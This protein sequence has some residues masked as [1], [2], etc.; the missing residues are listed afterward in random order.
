[1]SPSPARGKI[2]AKGGDLMD[3]KL[4]NEAK[5]MLCVLYQEYLNRRKIEIPRDDAVMFGD[6][7][8]LQT[9]LF[10]TWPT[11]DISST[12]RELSESGFL[13]VLFG[14]NELA[15]AALTKDAII[16]M[17]TRFKRGAKNLLSA[18]SELRTIIFP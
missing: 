17:E 4:T 12:A 16:Y 6:A 8:H 15:D 1:M 5:Y 7:E 2:R 3:E 10:P 9:L 18:I 14:D 11:H 13:S